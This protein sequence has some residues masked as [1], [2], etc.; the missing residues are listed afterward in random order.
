MVQYFSL[1]IWGPYGEYHTSDRPA[2]VIATH[3]PTVLP[4]VYS[5]IPFYWWNQVDGG[6]YLM[7]TEN[8][9]GWLNI[10]PHPPTILTRHHLWLGSNGHLW[11]TR[12]H[13]EPP[14]TS[15]EQTRGWA[16]Q[17][18]SARTGRWLRKTKKHLAASVGGFSGKQHEQ[19]T[20]R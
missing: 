18:R 20:G 19:N 11:H 16:R 13:I 5:Q 10:P 15:Y 1:P 12:P 9:F 6:V 14:T 8:S 17:L 4:A 3:F 7:D 2:K